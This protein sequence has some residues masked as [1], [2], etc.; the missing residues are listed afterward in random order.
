MKV[1]AFFALVFACVCGHAGAEVFVNAAVFDIISGS[2]SVQNQGT[3]IAQAS[4]S[5]NGSGAYAYANADTGILNG[6][7][8]RLSQ[9]MRATTPSSEQLFGKRLPFRRVR[10][11]LGT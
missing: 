6:S 10:P 8:P 2:N 3:S 7:L 4:Y 5:Q 11:G 9:S 1:R